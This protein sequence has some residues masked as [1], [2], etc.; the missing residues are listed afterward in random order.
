MDANNDDNDNSNL[1]V[2]HSDWKAIILCQEDIERLV[3]LRDD[4]KKK[5]PIEG[6]TEEEKEAR[7]KELELLYEAPLRK[8]VADEIDRLS[9]KKNEYK[10]FNPYRH[11]MK[12]EACCIMSSS[13]ELALELARVTRGVTLT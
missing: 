4:Y 11:D 8:V 10:V 1:A 9:K 2:S 3:K 7:D 12:D 5:N 6:L 13:G